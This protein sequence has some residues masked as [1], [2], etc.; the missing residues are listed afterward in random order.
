MAF[1]FGNSG[2]NSAGNA[3]SGNITEGSEL[4]LIQTEGL[5][6][7]TI[8]GDAKL[9]LTSAWTQP[10]A[11]TASLLTIAPNKGLVAAAGPDGVV[12][13][14]T[15]SVRKAFEN[16][17]TGDSETRNFQPQLKL[18]LPMR[19]SQIAFT[20]DEQYL[21][22]SAESGGG[23]AVY[24]TQ[25]LL[26]GATQATFELGTNGE[27]LRALVPNPTTEKAELCALLTTNG[28]L[29]MANF[30]ERQ[31]SN[32]LKSQVSCLSWS[33]KGKQLVAGLADGT[34]FQMTPEG[35]GKGEVPRPPSVSDSHVSSLHWLENNLFLTIHTTTNESPPTSVYHIIHRDKSNFTF[36]KMTDPV[37]PF[38]AEKAPHYSITRLRDFPPNLQ[39]LILVCSTASPDVGMLTRSKTPLTNDKPAA[40]IT[41]VFTTTELLDDSKRAQ[42]PMSDSFDNTIPIG[43][44]LDLSS[45]EKVYKPLPADEEI[46]ESPG[47]VPGYW[48]LNNEGVLCAWWVIYEESIRQGTTYPGM[49]GADGSISI[50]VPAAAAP[51]Q[52]AAPASAF[53]AP[54][55]T[56]GSSAFASPAAAPAFG[57]SS[58]LG[59]KS[60]PWG[61]PSTTTPA[62]SQPA[63]G[64]TAFGGAAAGSS[65]A[66]A[67]GQPSSLGFGQSSQLGGNKSPWATAG[68][69]AAS[70]GASSPA[71]GQS[72][73]TSPPASGAGGFASFASSGGFASAA[74]NGTANGGSIFGKPSTG[75]PFGAP[76][77][78]ASETAFPP[79]KTNSM[80]GGIFGSSQ[81]FKLQS[82]FEADPSQKDSN[83]K[84]GA[85]G[86]GSL[87][88][89]GFGSALGETPKQAAS[90]EMDMGT[91]DTQS[92][93]PAAPKS[94]FGQQQSVEKKSPFG[95]QSQFGA[96]QST[97]SA[98]SPFGSATPSPF[99][100]GATP[101][102]GKSIFGGQSSAAPAVKS[103]FSPSNETKSPF[104]QP[105]ATPAKSPFAPSK[106]DE[107]DESQTPKAKNPFS[108]GPSTQTSQAKN[109]FS[110]GSVATQSSTLFGQPS[111]PKSP[112]G[113]GVPESTT[114][115]TTPAPSRFGFPTSN[116]SSTPRG[117]PFGPPSGSSSGSVFSTAQAPKS[118]PE[119]RVE[120]D[121]PL[122]PE[123]TSRSAYPLGDSSASSAA[124]RASSKPES[125]PLP[126]D[127]VKPAPRFVAEEAPLP[128]DFVSGPK[129]PATEDAPLPPDFVSTPKPAVA[130][131]APLPPDFTTTPQTAKPDA[132]T[133][134][135]VF[136][137]EPVEDTSE[138]SEEGSD[139][140]PPRD[141]KR[142]GKMGA[143][144][145]KAPQSKKPVKAPALPESAGESDLE[146]GSDE[147][148]ESEG[149][150]VIVGKDTSPSVT[151]FTATPGFTPQSSFGGL[152]GK[153]HGISQ[154]PLEKPRSSLF[155]EMSRNAPIFPRPSATSPRSPSPL[156]TSRSILG[157]SKRQGMPS[158]LTTDPQLKAQRLARSR[159]EA[160][161]TKV[162]EDDED[163]EIQKLLKSDIE[164]TLKIDDFETIPAQVETVYRDINSMIDTLGLNAR[165]LA[166]F[167]KGHM[168]KEDL[169]N[170]EDWVLCEVNDL[171]EVIDR[172]LAQDLADGRVHDIEDKIDIC[173]DLAKEMSH[174]KKLIT[175]EVSKSLPLST[176]QA[177]QQTELQ[178]EEAVTLLK[179]R[180]ATLDAASGKSSGNVP[181]V[182]AMTSM[183][184]KR[185]GD[186]D[187]LE[188]QMRKLRF[189]SV[190]S[191]EDTPVT[192][193]RN[194]RSVMFS[195]DRGTSSPRNLRSSAKSTTPRKKLSGFSAD[196][197]AELTTRR[198]RRQGILDKLK[199]NVLK[200]DTE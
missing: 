116:D 40:A 63:F 160:A 76:P 84:P 189:S 179:T 177:A 89:S 123:S 48:V 38:G 155:G 183:V 25:S 173:Q 190:N 143:M 41:S 197:K 67:F 182:D 172:E 71:F 167:I 37:D 156:N 11:D 110:L 62:A 130:E 194:S 23:L 126:P 72:G 30:R 19:V 113:L 56:F 104:G 109:P 134:P 97:Q 98:A 12:I 9:Q 78:G 80:G 44:S 175:A 47:P 186:V 107:S 92:S 136:K 181:T 54:K 149:S 50:S 8:A 102:T 142:L 28:N 15:E 55:S 79:P 60:S 18:S 77:K 21:I 200:S 150:G 95:G 114:P 162:L 165:S 17:K 32:V 29:H 69:S 94:V 74:S 119:I 22:I 166:S 124:S 157:A 39:D 96:P 91:S 141:T 106:P 43:V 5:G 64:S 99:S 10:P 86:G 87:F 137:Y 180:L 42:L 88:G 57:G 36:Q 145:K 105:S 139:V 118:P 2:A 13:A 117:N 140:P 75:S 101:A 159:R 93:A 112:L 103:P 131:D 82:S 184:E 3:A 153:D 45:R 185:S 34:I 158:N 187:V 128:P 31:I 61:T 52:A 171:G 90:K 65:P 27:A 73:P 135:F 1:S 58:A 83:E 196:E 7:K 193:Q 144:A 127:F 24:E 198:A 81:P 108:S 70:T 85:G 146:E 154:T 115:T 176:E 100:T 51:A 125:A 191:R 59:A 178:A 53:A 35:E 111:G 4:E 66:P 195:P 121:V 46:E 132:K 68:T 133:A 49:A 151:G 129:S 170:A 138:S 16:E 164:P 174:L 152:G 168:H 169:E 188:N 14:S 6:F 163:D 161:E 26:Q 120:E 122:P 20:T 199:A 33:N 192:P 147:D 148:A